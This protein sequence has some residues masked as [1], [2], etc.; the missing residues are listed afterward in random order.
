MK[1]VFLDRESLPVPFETPHGVT[2]YCEYPYTNPAQVH[3]RLEHADIAILNKVKLTRDL[4]AQLPQLKMVSITAT[5]FD[6][7]DVAACQERHIAVT[8]V[9]QYATTSV[10]EHVLMLI[11][12]LRRNLMG[13]R[14]LMQNNAWPQS[15]QFC[16]FEGDITDVHA[17]TLGIVGYGSLGQALATLAKA[18]GMRVIHHSPSRL[19]HDPDCVSLAQLF[20]HSDVVSL[21]C[22]LTASTHHLIN[23]DTLAQMKPSSLLINT[24]RGALIDETALAEALQKGVIAGAGLDVLSQEPPPPDH[25]LL[26]LNLPQLI[27]TPHVAWASRKT[28]Q[29]LANEASRNVEHWL[30]GLHHNRVV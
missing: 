15:R 30:K 18:L 29:T 10:P 11:L 8:H 25:P 3:A 14:T 21:H 27:I 2:D 5:G 12:A 16:V 17:Q 22:P 7:V 13:Y 26:Q 1:A 4:I 23:R 6:C 9:K 28:M 20:Q 19:G 24:A